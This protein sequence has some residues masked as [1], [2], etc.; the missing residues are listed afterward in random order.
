MRPQEI[1][2]LVTALANTIYEQYTPEETAVRGAIL[3][4][5][6]DFLESLAA[7]EAL[8]SSAGCQGE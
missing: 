4:Q 6:G 8:N 1:S 5:L 3:T 7:L 2:L